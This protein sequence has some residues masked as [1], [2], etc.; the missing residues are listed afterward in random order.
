[1]LAENTRS[2]FP[3]AFVENQPCRQEIDPEVAQLNFIEQNP[4]A[5]PRHIAEQVEG[6]AYVEEE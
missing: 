1:L 4:R 5:E 3:K 6:R 2:C